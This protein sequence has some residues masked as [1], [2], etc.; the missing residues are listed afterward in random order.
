MILNSKAANL[1][2]HPRELS[3]NLPPP[4]IVR[5]CLGETTGTLFPGRDRDVFGKVQDMGK[6][7]RGRLEMEGSLGRV[8]KEGGRE[9]AVLS[10]DDLAVPWLSKLFSK[11]RERAS[12]SHRQRAKARRE[13]VPA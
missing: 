6:E 3:R 13:Q 2:T 1:A 12:K 7:V 8:E 5:S 10:P 11:S 4:P 9:S